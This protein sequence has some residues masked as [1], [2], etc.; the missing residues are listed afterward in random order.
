[1]D[2]SLFR[3]INTRVFVL[4]IKLQYDSTIKNCYFWSAW[5]NILDKICNEVTKNFLI[6]VINNKTITILDDVK[7]KWNMK[8]IILFYVTTKLVF[9]VVGAV[10]ACC[11]MF[12]TMANT[13]CYWN[14]QEKQMKW[15]AAR[16][17]F[18]PRCRRFV[19][20]FLLL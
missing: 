10:V 7:N 9:V 8:K 11:S 2:Y 15:R 19:S 16:F 12:M 4:S 5:R 13:V 1:M 18:S 20:T 3:K 6:R 17:F 14:K